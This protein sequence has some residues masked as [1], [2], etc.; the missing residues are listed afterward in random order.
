MHHPCRGDQRRSARLDRGTILPGTNAGLDA[1]AL[2]E[3]DDSQLALVAALGEE[4]RAQRDDVLLTPDEEHY[5]WVV[6][7]SGRIEMF[8][9][10]DAG[11]QLVIAYGP[12]QFIGEVS[13]VT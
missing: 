7:R 8:R 11:E 2:P 10:D 13:L 9:P 5:D 1:A 3:F 6:L 12:R 4:H